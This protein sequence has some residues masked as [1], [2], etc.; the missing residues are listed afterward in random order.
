MT[1]RPVPTAL[2]TLVAPILWGT[3]YLTVTET[4]PPDRPLLVA[5]IRVAPAGLV[6]ALVGWRR[7]GWRP[8][9]GEWGQQT[10]LATLN[11][12]LFFPLLI[13]A[14]YR[15]PGGVAASVGGTQPLLVAG[16]TATV[17]GRPPTPRQLAVGVVAALGVAMVVIRPGADV[18]AVGVIAALGA[19]VSFAGGVVATKRLP[20]PPDRIAATGYQ[21]LLAS[22]VLMLV[23]TVVEGPPP[24]MTVGNVVGFAYLGLV[25]TGL[26]FVLWF[27]GIRRLPVS[28]PPLLGLAAPLTG[29][30][31]GWVA[32]GEDLSAVQLAGFAITAAA[33]VDAAVRPGSAAGGT[34]PDDGAGLDLDHRAVAEQSGHRNQCG[35]WADVAEQLAV[36]S[37]EPVGLVDVGDEGPGPD[38]VGQRGP[39]LD[40][41]PLDR[42][43]DVPGLLVGVTGGDD[44]TV[45]TGGHR[46]RHLD[47]V[48]DADRPRI[49]GRSLPR[50]A[51]GDELP[52]HVGASAG[53]RRR[54]RPAS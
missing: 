5:A 32:L 50:A 2:L 22:G 43:E 53:C 29:A 48:V 17:T 1:T 21:L 4:L 33:I 16:L 8:H 28:V 27:R 14:V 47:P 49:A 45:W 20:S 6:L 9:G 12:A 44:G 13:V 15:L 24:P 36:G 40:Q 46:A 51:A 10:V 19:N 23:A 42:G 25:A 34:T 39:G 11:F 35:R 3:T 18:D 30:A 26:A 38:H 31:L 41:R 37:G 7:S 52:G 54:F